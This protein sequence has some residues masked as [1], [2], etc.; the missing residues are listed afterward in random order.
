MR[1]AVS[2][3]GGVLCALQVI[4]PV[5]AKEMTALPAADKVKYVFAVMG[6]NRI[7]GSDVDPSL[8]P[9]TANLAQLQRTLDDLVNLA[10]L[11]PD[12]DIKGAVAIPK[13]FFFTGDL[14]YGHT[15]D[16]NTLNGEL[17]AWMPLWENS[18]ANKQGI[19]LVPIPGNHEFLVSLPNYDQVPAIYQNPNSH[20]QQIWLNNVGP[21]VR[22]DNGPGPNKNGNP[23]NVRFDQ[24]RL[25]YSFD[26]GDSHFMV[27]NTDFA[28]KNDGGDEQCGVAN[29]PINWVKQDLAAAAS[30]PKTKHIFAFGHK[31]AFAAQGLQAYPQDT[32]DLHPNDRNQFWDTMNNTGAVAYLTAHM[33]AYAHGQPATTT[34]PKIAN[35]WQVIAGNAGSSLMSGWN[36]DP[37]HVK[38]NY[39]GFTTVKVYESG[40]VRTVSYGRGYGPG[41]MSPSDPRQYPTTARVVFDM[42]RP[43]AGE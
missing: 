23:D 24:S 3:I 38:N 17:A 18:A 27:M 15:S 10:T 32:M 1:I 21:Y 4:M 34:Q 40:R 28:C 11:D 35:T 22:G 14:V 20:V 13:Y 30:N 41:Y 12:G 29:T 37:K 25:T 6:C 33:H 16:D 42:S 36:S 7:D 9:S 31:P 2:A 26:D 8:N 5:S 43:A 19:R 39:F